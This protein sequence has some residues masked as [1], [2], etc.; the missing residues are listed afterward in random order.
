[1]EDL[2]DDKKLK[3]IYRNKFN[4]VYKLGLVN[5]IIRPT[6]DVTELQKGEEQRGRK[7]IGDII[8]RETPRVACF[9]GKVTYEKFIGSKNVV[10]GWQQ[11]ISSAR[12]F[13]MHFPLRG[14]AS[15]RVNELKRMKQ[16]AG[17]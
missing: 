15:V 14:E 17:L 13:V 6:R 3:E 7:R 2:R 12:V 5:V 9:I 4:K 8:K 16:V 10:F 1:M 11:D